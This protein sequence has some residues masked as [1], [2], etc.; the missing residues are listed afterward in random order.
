M[1]PI[2][3]SDHNGFTLNWNW[4][5]TCNLPNKNRWRVWRYVHADFDKANELLCNT[6]W[7]QL[8]APDSVDLLLS[9]WENHFMNIMEACLLSGVLPRRKNLPWL[10]KSIR[11]TIQR[12][13]IHSGELSIL[14]PLVSGT[15]SN[16]KRR[17][18]KQLQ[19]YG[20]RNNLFSTD[21]SIP[22]TKSNFGRLW[23][24]WE[25]TSLLSQPYIW[26]ALMLLRMWIN[27]IWMNAYFSSCFNTSLPPLNNPT[28]VVMSDSAPEST[29]SLLCSEEEVLH[30]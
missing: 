26:M 9:H 28:H 12:R 30:L 8:I 13:K 7:D 27:L 25:R 16:L 17:E 22:Q 19:C 4:K 3:N 15:N 21:T 11:C 24:R 5:S 1:P 2:S 20:T 10:S 6:D 18:I 23:K 29:D 14:A